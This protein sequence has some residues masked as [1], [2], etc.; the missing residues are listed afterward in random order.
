M[1]SEPIPAKCSPLGAPTADIAVRAG[2]GG[3]EAVE[4]PAMQ[5]II[6]MPTSIEAILM[7]IPSSGFSRFSR[8]TI[9]VPV[10][11]HSFEV[12]KR[13]RKYSR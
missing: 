10:K 3:A 2:D 11:G 4:Q 5:A 13:T 7:T 9:L 1:A 8:L 6:K 12:E